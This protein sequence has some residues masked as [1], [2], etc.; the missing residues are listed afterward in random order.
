MERVQST[1]DA[2]FNNGSRLLSGDQLLI[3]IR[4]TADTDTPGLGLSAD[5]LAGTI[6]NTLRE[7]LG[8]FPADAYSPLSALE[9]RE[10]SNDIARANT[11]SPV[12]NPSD[13]RVVDHHRLD[14]VESPDFQ[15]DVED[16]LRNGNGF[17]RFADP[18]THPY[19]QL[20]NDGGPEVTGRSNNCLDCA[21][22]ALSSFHGVPQ[23]SAPRWADIIHADPHNP[24]YAEV[25]RRSGERGGLERASTWLGGPWLS[26]SGMPVPAQ[27]DALH[28]YVDGLGPGSAALVTSW[29]PALD[30]NGDVVL[31]SNGSPEIISGHATVVV[32]PAGADGP[33][34]W[35]PQHGLTTD[36][37]PG[38]LVD[39]AVAM[40]CIPIDSNGGTSDAGAGT[41][42]GTGHATDAPGLR[43]RPEIL[44]SGEPAGLGLSGDPASG[45][46]APIGGGPGQRGDQQAHGSD[47]LAQQPAGQN[48]R[49]D[50]RHGDRSGQPGTGFPGLS[51]TAPHSPDPAGRDREHDRVPGTSDRPR[52]P[53]EPGADSTSADHQATDP[54]S[55]QRPPRSGSDLMGLR[56]GPSDGDLAAGRD[57]R[58]V[59]APVTQHDLR[60]AGQA[61]RA[62]EQLRSG[63]PASDTATT[64]AD[65]L[66]GRALPAHRS[67]E[68]GQPVLVVG[69][70]VHVTGNNPVDVRQ[71]HDRAQLTTDLAFN[72]GHRL[73]DG[74]WLMV[75]LVP[76]TDPAAAD[77]HLNSDSPRT[78]PAA[79]ETSLR[80]QLG[81]GPAEGQGLSTTDLARLGRQ[82][83]STPM[84]SPGTAD[85]SA[86]TTP[87]FDPRRAPETDRPAPAPAPPM[88]AVPPAPPADRTPESDWGRP[89]PRRR[90]EPSRWRR[91]FGFG[92]RRPRPRPVIVLQQDLP[93]PPTAPRPESRRAVIEPERPSEDAIDGT[94][95]RASP[96][97]EGRR[98]N[99]AFHGENEPGNPIWTSP[100]SAVRY[101]DAEERSRLRLTVRNGLLVDVDG[102]PFDTRAGSTHWGGQ[103]RAIFVMDLDGNLYASN[104]HGRGL[105]HHSS[106]LAGGAVAAAGELRVVDGRLHLLT[107][108]S[109][110]YRPER[111]H[112][113]QAI[114]RLRAL[115]IDMG[116][117]AIEFEAPR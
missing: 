114:S 89:N 58:A 17:D 26:Y 1:V 67:T 25:D 52:Q 77:L 100:P 81:L 15:H 115:G 29:F 59:A 117:V 111:G 39:D 20:V 21:L 108:S 40:E 91:W 72:R 51:E 33:V 92:E 44:D 73:P 31:D 19:G 49:G 10:I 23:V 11:D 82:V 60:N 62:R 86:Q 57:L 95:F 48:D 46:G 32:Y 93:R 98:M 30:A 63:G 76:V 9:L 5:R 105:F 14:N 28:H 78:D 99:S 35:D 38:Y 22:S 75:D 104:T 42:T 116:A 68:F 34:W 47:H 96:P 112:T 101:L 84:E 64:L 65:P 36:A 45:R 56:P 74:A 90:S 70:N 69:M 8:L 83:G 85:R 6:T 37:P 88:S 13:T 97:F 106:F 4:F 54:A 43:P 41:D 7:H 94:P 110:H 27:F 16:S 2:V 80:A 107:D 55:A 12:S 113:L 24:N 103:G 102:N 87:A 18:R 53:A 71:L 3:D 50:V 66:T 109:G 61:R 79:I